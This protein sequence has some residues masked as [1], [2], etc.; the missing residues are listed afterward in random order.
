MSSFGNI[1]RELW[2]LLP[3]MDGR[4]L[5]SVILL[6]VELL[7]VMVLASMLFTLLIY[8]AMSIGYSFNKHKK[9]LSVVFAFVFYH[10]SQITAVIFGVGTVDLVVK[11]M[12]EG[13]YSLAVQGLAPLNAG[14]GA[15]IAY[16]VLVCAAFYFVTHFFITKKLNLE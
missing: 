11:E 5:A 15:G 13:G 16:L 4:M 14:A 9:L 7:L 6:A 12:T 8:A 10:V 1:L 2:K 3:S